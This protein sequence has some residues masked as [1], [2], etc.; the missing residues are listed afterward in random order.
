MVTFAFRCIDGECGEPVHI[1]TMPVNPTDT[2]LFAAM[3]AEAAESGA[4]HA[5][6]ET[7]EGGLLGILTE[8]FE[9]DRVPQR[10]QDPYTLRIFVF[11]PN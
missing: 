6:V 8:R 10:W 9:T 5:T 11:P 2:D 7:G 1:E 4:R 3:F